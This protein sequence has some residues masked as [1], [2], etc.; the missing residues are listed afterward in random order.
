MKKIGTLCKLSLRY[1][2]RHIGK[3]C[4]LATVSI[5]GAAAL[6]LVTLFIRSERSFVLD[7][8]LDHLGD[9]DAV[10]YEINEKDLPLI[11]EHEQV[12]SSGSYRELGYA[13]ADYG[14]KYKVASF[15][16]K[17]SENMYHMTCVAGHY[18]KSEDEIAIDVNTAKELGIVPIVGQKVSLELFDLEKTELAVKDYTIAGMFEATSADVFG[19]C[20]RYPSSVEEYDVPVIFMSDTCAN[21]FGSSLFTAFMQT[22]GEI[23]EIATEIADSNFSAM[24]GYEIPSGGRTYAYANIMG[25]LDHAV[26]GIDNLNISNLLLAIK[27]GNV[28]K[29][30]YSS[31]L[32]PFFAFLIFIIV[33]VSVFSLVQNL[34]LDRSE[35]IAVLRSVGM[36]KQAA[37]VYL[38]VELLVL[39]S[40][41]AL[42]GLG[43]GSGL[44]YVLI[45]A[46]NAIYHIHMPFGFHASPYVNAVTVSPYLCSFLVLEISCVIAMLIPLCQML[47]TTP[48]AIFQKKIYITKNKKR[49]HFNQ[50]SN[51]TWRRVLSEHIRFHDIFVLVITTVVMSTAFFG[52][53]YF[54]ALSELNNTEEEF[55]LT[56]SGL[57]EWDYVAE[58]SDTFGTYNFQIENHHNY[59]IDE[60]TYLKLAEN[61]ALDRAFARIVN[62]STRLTYRKAE[63]SQ[64]SELLTPFS[65]RNQEASKDSYENALYEAENAMLEKIGY[66]TDEEIYSFPSIGVRKE[67]FAALSAHVKSGEINEENIK[68]G[69]EVVLVVPST[70]A[71]SALK[72]FHVG[73]ML[74]LSDIVLS[75]EEENY[76]FNQFLPSE[77]AEPIYKKDVVEPESGEKVELTSYAFGSRKNIETKI[78]AIVVLDDESLL[79]KYGFLTEAYEE[80]DEELSAYAVSVLCLPDTFQSWGLPDK[81]FTEVDF[82]LKEGSDVSEVNTQWYKALGTC[83][84]ISFRSSYEIREKMRTNTRKTMVVYELTIITLIVL[85]M[86]S[87]GIKFYSR[88][89]WQ[90]QTVARLRAL[91]MTLSQLETMIFRQNLMYPFIGAVFSVIPVSLCQAFFLYIRKCIDSGAWDEA[92]N[93]GTIPWW[94][95]VPFRYNLFGYHPVMTLLILVVVFICLTILATVP[96]VWYMKK[97]VIAESIDTDS[98]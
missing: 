6:C 27:E 65:L 71:D 80:E 85:G 22:D 16:D 90:S 1:W 25:V 39:I 33:I 73:D 75:A 24:S 68:M 45:R 46:I 84:G 63:S 61:K 40:L 9:Y 44:H 17:I 5:I 15:P 87:I 51:V 94:H 4:T 18:P 41:F 52:Y 54:R 64:L 57:T 28:W 8:T 19:G 66:Q 11:S 62:Q 92:Y 20:Y 97:Q 49:H 70:L 38:F 30:F 3:I 89:K 74:P 59:G 12:A 50:F 72:V 56:E 98:F 48:I 96:Q 14:T 23:M 37:F 95:Y 26:E 32:I 88:M 78:G 91:G 29:D 69:T 36:T 83:K 93:A 13:S 10:F 86:I 60:N 35:E 79:A 81:L 55:S 67:D 82:S 7:Q 31:V 21:L 42:I 76:N 43:V 34:I 77:Y 58:K 2:K 47:R 53:N